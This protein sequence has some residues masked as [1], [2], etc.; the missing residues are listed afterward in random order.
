MSIT[1][2]ARSCRSASISPCALRP[3]STFSCTVSQGKSA[4]DWKTMATPSPPRW[5]MAPW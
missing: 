5:A 1:R 2:K 4:N 3:S